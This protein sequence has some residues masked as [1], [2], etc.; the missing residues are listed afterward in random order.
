MLRAMRGAAETWIIKILMVFLVISFS[1]WGVGD[2]FRG[3]PQ[4]RTVACIGGFYLPLKF[5]FG[6]SASICTGERLTVQ[7]LNSDFR[8]NFEIERQK[9]GIDYTMDK[10]KSLGL[11]DRVL[12]ESIDRKLFDHTAKEYGLRY[13]TKAVI[14]QLAHMPDLRTK[15][16][17]FDQEKF[18]RVLTTSHMS[19]TE[20]LNYMRETFGRDQSVGA[21][22]SIATSPQT[23]TDQLLKAQG[24]ER[25]VQVL[26]L[27]NDKMPVPADPDMAT[28]EKFHQEHPALFTAPEYRTFSIL[29][30]ML[31]NAIKTTQVS[32]AEIAAAFEK[33]QK[34]YS[35]GE[36]RD[37]LQVVVADSAVAQALSKDAIATGD[38][39]KAAATAKKEIVAL[40]DQSED[41]IPP[42]LYTTVFTSE[43][44]SISEPI[45]TEFGYHIVQLVKI[46]PA[47]TA[48]L[49]D[50]K[51]KLHDKLQREKAK[52]SL[53]DIANQV[54]DALGAGKSL[55]DIAETYQLSIDKISQL[56]NNGE[57]INGK[58][59]TLPAS[60]VVLQNTFGL[61]E[62]D[63]SALIDDHLG[64]FLVVHLDKITPSQLRPLSD[65]KDKV[66]IEWRKEQQRLAASLEVSKLMA[67]W[68]KNPQAFAELSKRPNIA[69]RD[70]EAVS[71]L[72]GYAST[73][74]KEL[75]EE[76]IKLSPGGIKTGHDSTSQYAVRLSGFRA[77]DANKNSEAQSRSRNLIEKG[78][79]G[80][81]LDQFELALRAEFPVAIN[82]AL[83]DEMR[84]PDNTKEEQ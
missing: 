29:K 26:Q 34:E 32:D 60:A 69:A 25:L 62:G 5:I 7:A 51:E 11:M 33:R 24:Q 64:N 27:D 23:L 65:S 35:H 13:D 66:L 74:P 44:G 12:R 15:D 63:S 47:Y 81:V 61:N 53:Q 30:I 16:G 20:F 39:R 79:S 83:L 10:A 8:R 17:Q 43:V 57:D 4:Q 76:I 37:I 55:E 67:E 22:S 82:Q 14:A 1:I 59:T 9:R 78:W 41:T 48:V 40:D 42:A 36:L 19:E 75:Q 50:V 28:L 84:R 21:F 45:K 18:R 68:Q 58:K 38:L 77:F 56:D 52:E 71:I 6:W 2:M 46:K 54:D 70:E 80:D 72:F 49:A 3:N 73:L 31:D